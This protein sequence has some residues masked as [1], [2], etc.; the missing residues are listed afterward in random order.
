M[1]RTYSEEIDQTLRWFKTTSLYVVLAI[2]RNPRLKKVYKMCIAAAS[3]AKKKGS[4]AIHEKKLAQ[5][6]DRW[7]DFMNI[8]PLDP[9]D[10]PDISNIIR[11]H[12]LIV[13]EITPDKM[14]SEFDSGRGDDFL[15]VKINLRRPSSMIRHFVSSLVNEKRRERNIEEDMI[16]HKPKTESLAAKEEYLETYLKYLNTGKQLDALVSLT[17]NDVTDRRRAADH[18]RK[19]RQ[20][21]RKAEETIQRIEDMMI[22]DSENIDIVP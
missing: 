4:D 21:I 5:F 2:M 22:Q 9:P 16:I 10:L 7:F 3:D 6:I 13:N 11:S 12:S 8:N 18:K 17:L 20:H 19:I 14:R 15:L 1:T